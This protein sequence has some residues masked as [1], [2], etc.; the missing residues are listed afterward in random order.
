MNL[1]ILSDKKRRY[2]YEQQLGKTYTVLFEKEALP[3][4][5]ME[6]FTENYV[7]ISAKYD[8]ILVNELKE[9]KLLSINADNLVEV[10]EAQ[11][12]VFHH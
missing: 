9:V 6:G 1:E 8:P 2:F 10:C 5:Q 12:E 11:S 7:R 4:G 3:N